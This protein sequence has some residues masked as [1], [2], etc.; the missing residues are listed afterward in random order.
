MVT[1]FDVQSWRESLNHFGTD[2][3]TARR[4]EPGAGPSAQ[5]DTAHSAEIPAVALECR[6]G[7]RPHDPSRH[8]SPGHLADIPC[9]DWAHRR[10][11]RGI[12]SN[13][14]AVRRRLEC[15]YCKSIVHVVASSSS[16]LLDGVGR[17]ICDPSPTTDSR[18]GEQGLF[19][20]SRASTLRRQ[21]W[22]AGSRP[23]TTELRRT[24][25][26]VHSPDTPHPGANADSAGRWIRSVAVSLRPVG[27]CPTR[28]LPY[29]QTTGSSANPRSAKLGRQAMRSGS[30]RRKS[31]MRRSRTPNTSAA[32]MRASCAPRQK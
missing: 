18:R 4:A 5:A 19:C 12:E 20:C 28:S 26:S 13:P 29:P 8:R 10:S 1:Q 7:G 15:Q 23:A 16:P 21:G 3:A 17:K 27:A 22:M 31:G 9:Q 11:D 25:P 6:R 32:S 2:C 24:G 30:A 14:F